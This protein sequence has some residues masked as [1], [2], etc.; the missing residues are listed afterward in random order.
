MKGQKAHIICEKCGSNEI[1][2]VDCGCLSGTCLSCLNC[3]ELTGVYEWNE[4]NGFKT[5]TEERANNDKRNY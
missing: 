2:F 1:R 5:P 4:L 3:G